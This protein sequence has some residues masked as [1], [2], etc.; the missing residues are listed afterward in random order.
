MNVS[1]FQT[2]E[3]GLISVGLSLSHYLRVAMMG[4]QNG[5][6]HRWVYPISLGLYGA[7]LIFAHLVLD[8]EVLPLR[9]WA[10]SLIIL[11]FPLGFFIMKT[12]EPFRPEGLNLHRA[13][14]PRVGILVGFI[15][16]SLAAMISFRTAE[17]SYI[18]FFVFQALIMTLK[19]SDKDLAVIKK[20]IWLSAFLFSLAFV[21][22]HTHMIGGII[23]FGLGSALSLRWSEG[24]SRYF[25]EKQK[26]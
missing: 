26:V 25:S 7:M 13:M 22:S 20:M 10:G 15:L 21:V 2:L 3:I 19:Y 11:G 6:K 12:L 24:I 9:F 16:Y 17:V 4:H 8:T 14:K 1:I 23:F 18:C 5:P